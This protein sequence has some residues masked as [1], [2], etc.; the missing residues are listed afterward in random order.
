MALGEGGYYNG[1]DGAGGFVSGG[2]FFENAYD[3]AWGSWSGFGYSRVNDTVTAGWTNQFGAIP[4]TGVGGG[5]YAVASV[6]I[7]Y[8]SGTYATLS[9]RLTLAT[10]AAVQS[11]SVTNTTYAALAMRDGDWAAKRFGGVDGSDPD[12]FRLRIT[13]IVAAGQATGSVDFY[14]A[15]YRFAD[16][17]D[18]YILSEWAA[19]DLS[20]LGVVQSLDFTLASTDAGAFGMNTPAYFAL[21]NLAVVPE[22]ASLAMLAVGGL[23]AIRRRNRGVVALLLVAAM[24][25]GGATVAMAGPYPPAAGQP[26]ST[27][28]HMADAS[29]VAWATGYENMQYG[30][31]VDPQWQTPAKALGQ[32]VGG[33]FDVVALGRG[34]QVTLTFG[35]AITDGDGWDFAVFENGFSDTFLE[36][37][38]VEVSSDGTNFVRFANDSKTPGPV[39]GFGSV[40]PTNIT[41]LAGK[42]RQGYGTPFDLAELGGI[43]GLD[44]TRITHVRILDIVGDGT[45][46]DSSGDIIY[47]LYPTTG[48]AGFDLDAIGVIHQVP[49]P[50]SVTLLLAGVAGMLSRRRRRR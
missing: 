24:V 8:G 29:L 20:V 12:W 10:S 23:L 43:A 47:D 2:V 44:I 36:L 18:D 37:A 21:D 3:A 5:T 22:P 35:Q 31:F 33:S 1:A 50:A 45:Y 17:A 30:T 9:V 19:V 11:V 41:G 7:D 27:A 39:G 40:D 14:L 28:V 16:S 38:F 13:G 32:A 46:L 48:S 6:P 42:Y 15:D 4:G 26:G 34:G 49:E 25:C